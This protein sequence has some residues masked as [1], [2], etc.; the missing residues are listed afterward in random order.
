MNSNQGGAGM[1]YFQ[2]KDDLRFIKEFQCNVR[3]QWEYEDKASKK[4]VGSFTMPFE[5]QTIIVREASKLNGYSEIREINAKS[6]LR[7]IRIADL[8]GIPIHMKSY[9][10]PAVGGPVVSF[11]LFEVILNDTSHG[12][13]DRHLVSDAIN[14]T[15]GAC[16][17]S[18]RKEYYN[19]I[20]PL[21][22]IKSIFVFIIRIPFMLISVAGFNVG[23]FEDHFFAKLFKLI[24]VLAII[25]TLLRIGVSKGQIIE[26][27]GKFF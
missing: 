13:I 24:E 1:K 17:E 22:W 5:A 10:P 20:N 15:I 26:T 7:A 19:L 11:N 16:E 9:P 23:K 14:Q 4:L 18:L 12:G 3:K 25:Y 27:L 8:L 2:T 21:Y 6:I